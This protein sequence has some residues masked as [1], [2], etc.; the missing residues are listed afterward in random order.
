MNLLL[1]TKYVLSENHLSSEQ[2]S[3]H[4]PCEEELGAVG[5]HRVA[6]G[7]GCVCRGARWW[8]AGADVA[9]VAALTC[10]VACRFQLLAR[11][12]CLLPLQLQL[13]LQL[14]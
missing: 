11:R 13:H 8:H 5:G 10:G 1:L 3:A 6:L 12:L 14:L 4:L 2:V 7:Y 9:R